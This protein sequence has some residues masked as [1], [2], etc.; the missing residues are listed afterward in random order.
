M[1]PTNKSYGEIAFE[2][3]MND[4]RRLLYLNTITGVTL[5]A[6]L[7]NPYCIGE[8]RKDTEDL[9]KA[10]RRQISAIGIVK[11]ELKLI[12]TSESWHVIEDDFTSERI[13][14]IGVLLDFIS[15]VKNVAEVTNVLQDI[16]N[17]QLKNKQNAEA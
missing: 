2:D 7:N 6:I 13:E 9:K 4:L 3:L 15:G 12:G 5:D 17:E 16:F 14:D 10:I 1:T 8:N 11:T